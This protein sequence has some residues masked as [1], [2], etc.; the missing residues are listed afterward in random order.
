MTLHDLWDVGKIGVLAVIAW[1]LPPRYWRKAAIATSILGRNDLSGEA[2]RNNLAPAFSA[3]DSAAISRRRR[4]NTRELNIQIMGLVGPWRRSWR[5]QIRLIGGNH[6]QKSLDDSHGAILWMT[7]NSFST[8]IAKIALYD[9][10]YRACQL[11][12]PQHGF[13]VSRFGMRYLNPIWAGVEDRFIAERIVIKE[14]TAANA[15][16]IVRARLAANQ[17]VIFAV[18]PQAHRLAF[19]PFLRSRL[20]LPTGPIRLARETGA[21]LLP[22]FTAA[23]GSGGFEVSIHE[24]LYPAA[25]R[26]DDESVA[27]AYAKQLEAFV[28]KYP[29]QWNGWH[30]LK[31][32]AQ[33]EQG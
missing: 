23:N 27:A 5:P 18:V 10:G 4:V 2:Y 25:G 9:A 21:A 31:N 26:T 15:L 8:L 24:P 3:A 13:S 16:T 11:A 32:Q 7:E 29:D 6:L 14:K 1:L 19:T 22:V 33:P 20:P 17:S 30:W 28:L 12:R